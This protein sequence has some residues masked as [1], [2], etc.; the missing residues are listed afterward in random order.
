MDNEEERHMNEQN[1]DKESYSK[2][3]LVKY[4][5]LKDITRGSAQNNV[6]SGIIL[7][8]TRNVL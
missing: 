1:E 4:G 7:G 6:D 8:C 2:P 5:N 3:V